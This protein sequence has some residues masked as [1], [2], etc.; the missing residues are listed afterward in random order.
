M[1]LYVYC[2]AEHLKNFET[3][4]SGIAEQEVQLLTIEGLVVPAS[5]FETEAIALTRENVLR[6]ESIVR[7]VF[8][9]TTPLP[10]RFGTLIT[11]EA[12]DSF[13]R[14]RLGAL[15]D[16][17]RAVRNSVEMSVK[18][19]WPNLSER[20]QGNSDPGFDQS[21]MGPGAAY[22][23]S[24]REEFLGKQELA[25]EAKAIADWVG[26]RLNGF[27]RQHQVSVEPAQKIVLSGSYLIERQRE[28]DFRAELGVMRAERPNLHFLL[29][30]PWPPYTF[31]NIDLEFETHFGVS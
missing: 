4:V 19:I 29:S 16:R 10:F 24:R 20:E 23:I 12:L 18:I 27:S 14:S 21:A 13:I 11:K 25:E 2:V 28:P 30:G 17:L 8:A 5:N 7:K 9:E 1:K 22:L 26:S 15:T 6:H 3:S 31:A